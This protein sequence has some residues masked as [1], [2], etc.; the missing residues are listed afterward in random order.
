MIERLHAGEGPRLRAVRLRALEDA[1]DAF[2]T[3]LEQARA[4]GS[5]RWEAQVQHLPTFVWRGA[6]ADLGM[7]RC[8]PH[9]GDPE[10][11]YLVSMWVA[12]EARG[13]GIGTALVC[14]VV[15]WANELGV[16]RLVLDVGVRNVAARRFYERHGFI[17][18]GVTG[19]LPPPRAHVRELE[20]VLELRPTSAGGA[21]AS[22]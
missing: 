13:R 22:T 18:S 1:P 10:A 3:T 4:W 21:V 9:D 14:A 17:E 7:V 19:T 11:R 6:D 8:A 12:A 20:M 2:A 5:E 16:K 15:A